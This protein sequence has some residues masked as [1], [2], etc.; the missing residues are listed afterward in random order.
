MERNDYRTQLIERLYKLFNTIVNSQQT[1]SKEIELW[2]LKWDG[3]EL[4]L[5]AATRLMAKVNKEEIWLDEDISNRKKLPHFVE[6]YLL[7]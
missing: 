1:N 3:T 7:A 2:K 6:S 5:Y 4:K